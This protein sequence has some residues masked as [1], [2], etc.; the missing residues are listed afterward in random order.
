MLLHQ[1]AYFLFEDT[2]PLFCK[3]CPTKFSSLYFHNH[4]AQAIAETPQCIASIVYKNLL[5]LPNKKSPRPTKMNWQSVRGTKSQSLKE[6]KRL[7]RPV[8][9]PRGDRGCQHPR[10]RHA[11]SGRR[12]PCGCH[13]SGQAR[14]QRRTRFRP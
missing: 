12:R 4:V 6:L 13:R 10:H 3:T 1:L 5:D 2:D 9:E 8:A 7:Q 14:A 11:R